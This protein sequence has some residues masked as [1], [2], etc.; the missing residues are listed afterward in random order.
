MRGGDVYQ[1]YRVDTMD[2]GRADT[3]GPV[4]LHGILVRENA[5][6]KV[7]HGQAWAL[8]GWGSRGRG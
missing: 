2:T 3:A 1:Y 7:N 8:Q 5:R 6:E 4:C